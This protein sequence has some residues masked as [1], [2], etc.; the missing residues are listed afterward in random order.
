MKKVFQAV[1]V[2]ILLGIG[3]AAAQAQYLA[4]GDS[5]PFGYDPTV[6]NPYAVLLPVPSDLLNHYHGYPQLVSAFLKLPLAN[7]ACPGQTS[8]SFIK[9]DAPDNGCNDWRSEVPLAMPL[10]VT[11]SSLSQSQLDYAVAFLL[12]NPKTSL[13]TITIGGDDLLLLENNCAAKRATP[14]GIEVYELAGLGDILVTFAKNLTAIYLAIRVR[15]ALR[16]THR[17]CQL[18]FRPI[19]PMRL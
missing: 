2:L 9:V 6:W 3:T 10:F 17:R 16:G 1:L 12:K 11:Y 8:G 7:A 13:V 14:A 5:I 19:M 18:M 4:L 15:S